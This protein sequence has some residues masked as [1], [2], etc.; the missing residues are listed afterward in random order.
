MHRLLQDNWLVLLELHEALGLL[1]S[2]SG[3]VLKCGLWRVTRVA[4]RWDLLSL[5]E[6]ICLT[7]LQ[8]EV[9]TIVCG[10]EN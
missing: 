3:W 10:C 9:H 8:E 2:V 7:V 4:D 5:E 1:G 6:W